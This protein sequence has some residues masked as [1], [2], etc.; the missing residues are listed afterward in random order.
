MNYSWRTAITTSEPHLLGTAQHLA[1][2]YHFPYIEPIEQENFDFILILTTQGLILQQPKKKGAKSLRIN[3]LAGKIAYRL[4]HIHNQKQLLTK[5]IGMK[6]HKKARILDLTAGLGSDGFILAQLGFSI[7]LLERS[8]IIAML[9]HDALQRA[10]KHQH[11]SN[12]TIQLIHTDAAVYLKQI[13]TTQEFPD[14]IYL[15]PMYPHSKKSA[16]AKKEMCFLREIVGNDTDAENLLPLA[17]AGTKQRVVVKRPGF[18]AF[19]ADLKP[20]HSI[21][22]K[23]HRFDIYIHRN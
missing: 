17:L 19:L 5:A 4:R 9:L 13:I 11:Y 21:F 2:Q 23:Q 15:D 14:I 18:A 6:T 12:N 7:T 22:G 1:N 3:F 10:L 20:H 8:P 16:L